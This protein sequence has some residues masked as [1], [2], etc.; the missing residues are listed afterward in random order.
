MTSISL[1][2][3]LLVVIHISTSLADSRT[4]RAIGVML[5]SGTVHHK[6]LNINFMY[7]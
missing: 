7:T 5:N 2:S 3:E 6:V 4:V 1:A